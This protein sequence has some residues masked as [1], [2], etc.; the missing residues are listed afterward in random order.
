MVSD[1][2]NADIYVISNIIVTMSD[3]QFITRTQFITDIFKPYTQLETRLLQRGS[4]I[5]VRFI[6]TGISIFTVI[7]V[8]GLSS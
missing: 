8:P 2:S 5:T 3:L 4:L 1:A 7:W 6:D